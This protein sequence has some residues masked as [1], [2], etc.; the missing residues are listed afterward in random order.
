MAEDILQKNFLYPFIQLLWPAENCIRIKDCVQQ[1][2][3][4]FFV[5]LLISAQY[6]QALKIVRN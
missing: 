6:P 2:D 5:F 3:G 1:Y 4:Q